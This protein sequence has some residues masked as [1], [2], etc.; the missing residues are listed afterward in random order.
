MLH[1]FLILHI[2]FVVKCILCFAL[3]VIE[4][5]AACISVP[6][7]PPSLSE[8]PVTVLRVQANQILARLHPSE[9]KTKPIETRSSEM[10]KHRG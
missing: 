5:I 2:A 3:G 10:N 9:N 4:V 8:T 7:T 6:S 1:V